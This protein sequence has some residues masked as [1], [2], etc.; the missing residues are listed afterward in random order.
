MPLMG[1]IWATYIGYYDEST[2]TTQ[3]WPPSPASA[4]VPDSWG[5]IPYE[6][7]ANPTPDVPEGLT[8]GVMLVL[9]SVAAV[10]SIRYFRKPRK[11]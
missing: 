5:F 7:G 9:S 8:L 10:V 4:D 11:L 3:S 1:Y 2:A 6:T